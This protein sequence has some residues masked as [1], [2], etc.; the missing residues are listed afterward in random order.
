MSDM[1]IGLGSSV[2]LT[3]GTTMVFG[4]IDGIKLNRGE[5]E[6]VSIESMD[7]WFWMSEGWQ[8][9]SEEEEENG[10]IQPE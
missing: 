2:G 1:E 9:I 8:F 4:L 5:I 10:E 3:R 6:R 7:Y